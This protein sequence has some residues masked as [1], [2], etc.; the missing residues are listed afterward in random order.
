[1]R[2][3]FFGINLVN[4]GGKVVGLKTLESWLTLIQREHAFF[5]LPNH[6]EYREVFKVKEGL[7]E[8]VLWVDKTSRKHRA[9][10]EFSRFISKWLEKNKIDVVYNATNIPLISAPCK[11]VMLL[12]RAFLIV[13]TKQYAHNYKFSAIIK[14]KLEQ[15]LLKALKKN[16][17]HWIVQTN[18]MKDSLIKS[19]NLKEEN[20]SIIPSGSD[21]ITKDISIYTNEKVTSDFTFICPTKYYPH[22]K[23]ELLPTIIEIM[24]NNSKKKFKFLLTLDK[25]NYLDAKILTSLDPYIQQGYIQNVGIVKSSQ[26]ASLYRKADALFMPTLL[27]SF[28]LPFVEALN[29]LLPIATSNRT[30]AREICGDAATY[31]EPYDSEDVANKLVELIKNKSYYESLQRNCKE[32]SD[33]VT[34]SWDKVCNM[35]LQKII[36]VSK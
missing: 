4:G 11:Q 5:I 1:M 15:N 10:L 7:D 21:I 34:I 17:N 18:F 13:P 22:K 16:V 12:H 19:L 8:N 20:V 32:Q 27:E 28:G 36:E 3:A 30:F 6:K 2:I 9:K 23:L 25:A 26:M 29:S 24:K 31:F 35:T 14:I 33:L